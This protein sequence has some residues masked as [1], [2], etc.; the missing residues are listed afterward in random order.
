MSQAPTQA[1]PTR[2]ALQNRGEFLSKVFF[3]AFFS[4][5]TVALGKAW[6]F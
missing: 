2:K 6:G 3:L 1:T 4:F 5:A